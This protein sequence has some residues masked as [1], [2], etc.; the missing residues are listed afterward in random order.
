MS[1]DPDHLDDPAARPLDPERDEP[2]V[3][4]LRAMRWPQADEVTR[5]RAL[6]RF[7]EL[8]DLPEPDEA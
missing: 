3:A 6:L 2:L 8:V 1:P 5:E 4:R 7:R